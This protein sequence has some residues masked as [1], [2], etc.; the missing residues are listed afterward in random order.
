MR[1]DV[2]SSQYRMPVF[3]NNNQKFLAHEAQHIDDSPGGCAGCRGRSTPR[4]K[5]R[6]R[7]DRTFFMPLTTAA[8]AAHQVGRRTGRGPQPV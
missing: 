6:L 3:V 4:H 8:R 1:M 5:S 2:P 7:E